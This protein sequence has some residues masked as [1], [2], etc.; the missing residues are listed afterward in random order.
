MK[1]KVW[2]ARKSEEGKW[3]VH[4]HLPIEILIEEMI[5]FVGAGKIGS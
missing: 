4:F 1:E 3:L 5:S 2:W